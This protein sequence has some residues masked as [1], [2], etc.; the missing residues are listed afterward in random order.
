MNILVLYIEEFQHACLVFIT[1]LC[2]FFFPYY[3]PSAHFDNNVCFTFLS[4]LFF[5]FSFHFFFV[6][7]FLP[8]VQYSTLYFIY[9][10]ISIT[11][12][13]KTRPYKLMSPDTIRACL[14]HRKKRGKKEDVGLLACWGKT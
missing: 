12:R 9:Y 14:A 7:L 4:F 13:I 8:T 11:R 10:L 6:C 1:H 5:S 3:I 2:S